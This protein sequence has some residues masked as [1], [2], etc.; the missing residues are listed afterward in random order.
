VRLAERRYGLSWQVVPSSMEELFAG[1]DPERA[2]RAMD[3]MLQMGK[4]DIAALHAAA[5]GADPLDAS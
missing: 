3:A 5:D 4:L 1:S 2:R